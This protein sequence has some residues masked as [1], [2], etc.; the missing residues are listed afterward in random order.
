MRRHDGISLRSRTLL[1]ERSV[2]IKREVRQ[3][4]SEV[5]QKPLKLRMLIAEERWIT[6]IHAVTR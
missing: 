4:Y 6:P 5:R 3:S 1:K 2:L